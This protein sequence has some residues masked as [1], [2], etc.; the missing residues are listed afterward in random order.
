VVQIALIRLTAYYLSHLAISLPI[1]QIPLNHGRWPLHF[2]C[3]EY[4]LQ[5]FFERYWPKFFALDV[6]IGVGVLARTARVPNVIVPVRP[7]LCALDPK[8]LTNSA[9]LESLALLCA[10]LNA[11]P[12]F[13]GSATSPPKWNF[14]LIR[15]EAERIGKA[16]RRIVSIRVEI[17]AT[18]KADPVLGQK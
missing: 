12:Y 14:W 9:A 6:V 17:N 13:G 2:L 11:K 5:Y 10:K 18:Q 1:L 16:G 4:L 3:L 15:G 8:G 7:K